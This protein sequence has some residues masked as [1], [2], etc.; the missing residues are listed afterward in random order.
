MDKTGAGLKVALV[1]IGVLAGVGGSHLTVI[2]QVNR[3][4]SDIRALQ[5]AD[6]LIRSDL[7]EERKRNDERIKNAVDVMGRIADQNTRLIAMLEA[8]LGKP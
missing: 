7:I 4:E 8:K 6:E 3:S 5:K 2:A 1:V